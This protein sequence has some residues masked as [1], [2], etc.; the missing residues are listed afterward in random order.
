MFSQF[1]DKGKLFTNVVAKKPIK[2]R[3]QVATHLILGTVYIRPENRL[4]DEINQPETF[5][6][7]TDAQ[8]FNDKG[9]IVYTCKFIVVN[10]NQILWMA[11]D[12]EN[13]NGG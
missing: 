10:R 7:V 2:V 4:K 9:E 5:L 11:P 12:T 3:L 8:L 1:D 6:A 13:E